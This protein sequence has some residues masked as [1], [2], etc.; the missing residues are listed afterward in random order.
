MKSFTWRTSSFFFLLHSSFT[1]QI[2]KAA[3][4]CASADGMLLSD[5]RATSE[6]MLKMAR[7]DQIQDK[8]HF[9]AVQAARER[10]EFEKVLR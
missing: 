5:F 3:L 4:L 8:E 9:L 2:T 1:F 7:Q 10:A 6:A